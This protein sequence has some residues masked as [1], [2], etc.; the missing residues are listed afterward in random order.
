MDIVGLKTSIFLITNIAFM[1]SLHLFFKTFLEWDK[2][3]IATICVYMFFYTTNSLSYLLVN[4]PNMT[5][6]VF[7]GCFFLTELTCYKGRLLNKLIIG[8]LILGCSFFVEM[9]SAYF[10][11]AIYRK[12]LKVILSNEVQT[13]MVIVLSKIGFFTLALYLSRKNLKK[14]SQLN[15]P[16]DSVLFILIPICSILVIMSLF[17]G[18]GEEGIGLKNTLVVLVVVLF[19]I[20]NSG[21]YGLLEILSREYEEKSKYE[22]E[23]SK[24]SIYKENND[25]QKKNIMEMEKYRH[26]ANRRNVLIRRYIEEKKYDAAIELLTQ[27]IASFHIGTYIANTGILE[28]DYMLNHKIAY[29]RSQKVKTKTTIILDTKP[30]YDDKEL[31]ILIGNQYDIA[32]AACSTVLERP[33]INFYMENTKN[34]LHISMSHPC[35]DSN[36]LNLKYKNNVKEI[37]RIIKKYHGTKMCDESY[38]YYT[39]DILLF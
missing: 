38:S 39:V 23:L 17:V 11:A 31:C 13:I 12:F 18:E 10:I 5:F 25:I 21:L 36:V 22:R 27:E 34:T 19:F 6:C 4:D 7:A 26:D 2:N 33:F 3:Y 9:S 15:I 30:Q 14:Q 37:D 8:A 20:M 16:Y 1:V 35:P 29:A 24:A 32:I 28:L